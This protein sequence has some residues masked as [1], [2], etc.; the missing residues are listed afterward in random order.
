MSLGTGLAPTFSLLF[1]AR[2]LLLCIHPAFRWAREVGA[3]GT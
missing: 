2:F 3:P 1:A